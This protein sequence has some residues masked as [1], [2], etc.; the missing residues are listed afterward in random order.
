[1][2]VHGC[3]GGISDFSTLNSRLLAA[4]HRMIAVDLPAHGASEGTMAHIPAC[5][6]RVLAV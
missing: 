4:G 6:A 3:E 2:L 5:A 1:L